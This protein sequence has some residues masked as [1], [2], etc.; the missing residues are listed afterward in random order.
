[1][2]AV[3]AQVSCW[4][5]LKVTL[6]AKQVLGLERERPHLRH[7]LT[8]LHPLVL[9]VMALNSNPH[10]EDCFKGQLVSFFY[11]KNSLQRLLPRH[12]QGSLVN[13]GAQG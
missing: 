6:I 1:M 9:S 5:Q 10:W 8:I 11:V 7:H 12:V 13:I 2:G 4:L 3:M